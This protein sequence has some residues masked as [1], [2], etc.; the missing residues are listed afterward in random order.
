MASGP[1]GERVR[2]AKRRRMRTRVLAASLTA[3]FFVAVSPLQA[4]AWGSV[5]HYLINRVA[6][7]QLPANL[8]AFMHSPAAV[9]EVG[10]L[11]PEAD[12]VKG[13]G[14][15]FDQDYDHGHFMDVKDDGTIA[16][17]VT[18][19]NL[20]PTRE[21]F[22]T[23]L[24]AAGTDQYKSG[25]VAYEIVDGYERAVTDFAYWRIAAAAERAATTDDDKSFFNAQRILREAVALRD[26][27]YWGHFVA[28]ASQPLHISVHYNGWN[29][30]RDDNYPNPKGFSNSHSIH[31]R[32]E[33][34]LVAAV[35]TDANITALVPAYAPSTAPIMTQ[36]EDYL[37][38]TLAGVPEVYDL[39]NAGG[40]DGRSPAAKSFVLARLAAGAT[41]FRNLI[42]EAW[43]ES[44]THPV[45]YPAAPASTFETA[46]DLSRA[47]TMLGE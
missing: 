20:P 15:T 22:D 28:D 5:G 14:E 45:G 26:I 33:S 29:S 46:P 2:A 19:S 12:R 23:A 41:E 13:S 10:T 32:F 7:E 39:E 9:F 25:Y 43:T 18:L 21:A 3:A 8:P 16:G 42:A 4:F 47:R 44:A 37:K 38:A 35:A 27:G 40:I 34:S 6:A 17:S 24:R 31:A 36:V 1:A 11:G 30:N